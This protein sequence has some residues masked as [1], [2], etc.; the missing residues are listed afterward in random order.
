MQIDIKKEA[1][2][3]AEGVLDRAALKAEEVLYRA[4]KKGSDMIETAAVKAAKLIQEAVEVDKITDAVNQGIVASKESDSNFWGE[5]TKFNEE[6][7]QHFYEHE[8]NNKQIGRTLKDILEAQRIANGRVRK[9]EDW[10]AYSSGVAIVIV[11]IV[12]PIIS[13]L[14]IRVV[15]LGNTVSA[16][17]ALIEKK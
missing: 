9:L 13:Y 3:D 7:R 15:D 11:I 17:T 4:A 5:Q 1:A 2:A 12:V 8:Q 10:K 14:A 16:N 6:A